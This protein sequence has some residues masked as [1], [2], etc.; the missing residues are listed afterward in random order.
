MVLDPASP[1]N[2]H[3]LPVEE[4]TSLPRARSLP[5]ALNTSLSLSQHSL[6][7]A[8]VQGSKA[9][10]SHGGNSGQS[11]TAI[12]EASCAADIPQQHRQVETGGRRKR[13]VVSTH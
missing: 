8:N 7:A 5:A 12:R 4:E 11:W 9:H 1:G 13:Q 6:P 3:Q 10:F 2:L